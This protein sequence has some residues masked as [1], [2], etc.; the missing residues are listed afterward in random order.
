MARVLV[1]LDL[2]AGLMESLELEWCGQVMVQR[3][4]YQGL[5]FR[6]NSCRRTGHLRNDCPFSTGGGFQRILWNHLPKIS[7]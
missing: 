4:D 3:L 5:P 6:C 1:E 7:T 2:H